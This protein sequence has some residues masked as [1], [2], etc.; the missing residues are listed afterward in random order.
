MGTV[1]TST[2]RTLPRTETAVVGAG[3]IGLTAL[4][5]GWSLQAGASRGAFVVGLTGGVIVGLSEW[6]MTRRRLASQQRRRTL[7]WVLTLVMVAVGVA[8]SWAIDGDAGRGVLAFFGGWFAVMATAR[9][10]RVVAEPELATP[11]RSG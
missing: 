2:V 6:R 4:A 8:L 7:E 10:P 3:A 1:G 9:R 5:A 11:P